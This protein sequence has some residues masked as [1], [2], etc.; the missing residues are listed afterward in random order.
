M[1][2][3]NS[4]NI[5]LAG[6]DNL[7]MPLRNIYQ[8]AQK[9]HGIIE[10]T[11]II[12]ETLSRTLEITANTMSKV[13]DNAGKLVEGVFYGAD[14][15]YDLIADLTIKDPIPHP[16]VKVPAG[17]NP[18]NPGGTGREIKIAISYVKKWRDKY[19][20]KLDPLQEV[21]NEL[22]KVREYVLSTNE[23]RHNEINYYTEE[24]SKSK[25]VMDSTIASNQRINLRRNILK[26]QVS[27]A[28]S[29]L[30]DLLLWRE[31][32]LRDGADT[33]EIDGDIQ[34]T[35]AN[36]KN[37]LK[38]LQD[39]TNSDEYKEIQ[40]ARLNVIKMERKLTELRNVTI[41]FDMP[42]MQDFFEAMIDN[43]F[44][45]EDEKKA[46]DGIE[47]PIDLFLSKFINP[48]FEKLEKRK[49]N[50]ERQVKACDTKISQLRDKTRNRP[51]K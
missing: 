24:L 44:M 26:D 20:E 49:E 17:I 50:A 3:L 48:N 46:F 9:S 4:K 1:T 39:L 43:N 13:V 21:F 37:A 12:G 19:Q 42:L 11:F 5:G 34:V 33:K 8:E 22:S 14:K 45:T 38:A 25:K 35:I 18:N 27:Q 28:E 16:D 40:T 23:D 15:F 29:R 41:S 10:S 2:I 6:G 30:A 31:E 47:M 7:F 36:G 32:L 51:T